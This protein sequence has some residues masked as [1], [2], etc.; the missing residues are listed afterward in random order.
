[1]LD[2]RYLLGYKLVVHSDRKSTKTNPFGGFMKTIAKKITL[3]GLGA[4]CVLSLSLSAGMLAGGKGVAKAEDSAAPDAKHFFY[5]NLLDTENKEYTLAKRFYEVLDKLNKEEDFKDG[6]VDYNISNIVTSA[7]LKAWIEDGNLEVPRAFAA[8]RDAFLTDHPEI[9]Y[10]N[11][12]KLTISVGKSGGNYVGY[13]NSG[14]EANLFYDNGFNTPA[15]VET[16]ITAY[17]AKVNEIVDLVTKKENDNNEYVAKDVYLAKEV[18]IYLAENIEY[19]YAAYDNKDDANYVAEAYINTPYG[20]LIEGKAVCGGFSTSYKVIMDAL[21]IPCI[22]VNGYSNN[23]NEY[24]FNSSASVYHMWNYVWLENPAEESAQTFAASR[25]ASNG[26]WY[27]MDV[28]WNSSSYSRTKYA[29]MSS[30]FDAELHVTDG[31][32]S[33]SGYKLR[34][35]ELSPIT[36][37]S[38][39]KT[40]GLQVSLTYEQTGEKDDFQHDLVDTYITVSYNGKSAKKLFEEDGLYLAKRESYYA[41]DE[42]GI[43]QIKW[44]NWNVIEYWRRVLVEYNGGADFDEFLKDTGTQTRYYD[45]SSVYG[46]Q[47]AIFDVKPDRATPDDYTGNDPTLGKDPEKDPY[48]FYYY[49]NALMNEINAVAISDVKTNESYGTYTPAPYVDFEAS[50]DFN[51]KLTISDAM[52]DNKNNSKMNPNSAFVLKVKYDQPLHIL[53]KT[54]PIGISFTSIHPN[55]QEYAFF[56]PYEDGTYVKL[57]DD[58]TVEFKFCPSLMYEHND[59][60]YNFFFSNLGSA[61]K[62]MRKQPDGTFKEETLN[63]APNSVNFGFSRAYLA[64]PARFNYDGRLW[65]DCCAQPELVSNSDLS[66]DNFKDENGNSLFSEAER[67]QMMLVAERADTETV[68]SIL[69]GI[70]SIEGSNVSKGDVKS[71]ETYDIYLQMCG[72]YPTIPDGSYV[73]IALGFPEGYGPKDEGVTFKLYHRKH[74]QGDEYIIEE[75]PCVVTQFGIVACVTSFSPYMVAVVDADKVTDKI[76][77]ASIEGKGG[78]LTNEDGRIISF[79]KGDTHTYTINPDKGYLIYSVTLNGV[80]VLDRVVNGKL[81]LGYDDLDM[82]NQLVIQYISTEAASR[83]QQKLNNNVIDQAIEVGKH[84][85]GT[86]GNVEA[87]ATLPGFD[88]HPDNFVDVINGGG[89]TENKPNVALIAVAVVLGVLALVTVTGVVVVLVRRKNR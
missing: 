82:N 39:D 4:A 51:A 25:A 38:T 5:D 52:R 28:T 66:E 48:F 14:R 63:K 76:T 73:K 57:L 21:G 6:V 32:I 47:I 43:M 65:V 23:K 42:N 84:V 69:D 7:Q 80:N 2:K 75:V 61:R 45:N 3:A 31:V 44:T 19:D 29:V 1:M 11:F 74:I 59:M 37:G 26:A 15:S 70:G 71:S 58:Y 64:C 56:V 17:N 8:A 87:N 60:G 22:T 78:T 9:F 88:V 77:Y 41:P 83:I 62:V 89:Q 67:S 54:Q 10:I 49:S 36:Y 68:D 46:I 33:S 34:Y 35:P 12:Y 55:T 20:G 18:N 24:G 79:K 85:V 81:T 86:D 27:S 72:K 40:D 13:L 16:A 50:P 53:D 30:G